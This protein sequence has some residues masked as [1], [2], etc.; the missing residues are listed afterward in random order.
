M[1]YAPTSPF[2]ASWFR[3]ARE[4]LLLLDPAIHLT[5]ATQLIYQTPDH[6]FMIWPSQAWVIS[7]QMTLS[8]T[9]AGLVRLQD[10]L[11]PTTAEV[12]LDI[13]YRTGDIKL[14]T[15]LPH[16][17]V[18]HH[19]SYQM[20]DLAGT[21]FVT[22]QTYAV[23]RTNDM[24]IQLFLGMTSPPD[25]VVFIAFYNL[26]GTTG[27]DDLQAGILSTLP[28]STLDPITLFH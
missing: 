12:T 26:Q 21:G 2:D 11:H 9:I 5:H 23:S 24:P 13:F 22:Q 19:I 16:K 7:E 8:R 25:S 20:H 3:L 17:M 10:V 18:T 14:F 28:L 1:L 15:E 6:N 4:D 27:K